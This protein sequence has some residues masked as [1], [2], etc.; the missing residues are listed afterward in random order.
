M[1]LPL[2][3][4]ITLAAR[5]DGGGYWV[6]ALALRKVARLEIPAGPRNFR[7]YGGMVLSPLLFVAL[8]L[9]TRMASNS[10]CVMRWSSGLVRGV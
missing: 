10:G 3:K 8:N 5:Q 1:P 6:I 2:Y 9:W 7:S 4:G